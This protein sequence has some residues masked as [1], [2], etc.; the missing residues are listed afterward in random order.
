[1]PRKS[2]GSNKSIATENVPRTP[3]APETTCA[4]TSTAHFNL[5]PNR[6]VELGMQIDF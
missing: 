5:P 2:H 1:V 4:P 3:N 6:V